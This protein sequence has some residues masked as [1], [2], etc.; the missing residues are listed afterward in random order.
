MS[1]RVLNNTTPVQ[2]NNTPVFNSIRPLS[3]SAPFMSSVNL[4]RAGVSSGSVHTGTGSAGSDTAIAYR[5]LASYVPSTLYTNN[6]LPSTNT[7]FNSPAGGGPNYL[8]GGTVYYNPGTSISN[9]VFNNPNALRRQG[10]YA[11]GL[12]RFRDPR[13]IDPRFNVPAVTP[14]AVPYQIPYAYSA[15]NLNYPYGMGNPYIGQYGSGN[16]FNPYNQ[17][18]RFPTAPNTLSA[19]C[20]PY[21]DCPI[22]NVDYPGCYNCVLNQGGNVGCASQ[23]CAGKY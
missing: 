10:S 4:T 18:N 3:Y 14:Y 17:Y 2:N 13:F 11:P 15:Y 16:Q 9:R 5:S 23:L 7:I 6:I 19:P 22:R 21:I 12:E 20:D 1:T 8:G